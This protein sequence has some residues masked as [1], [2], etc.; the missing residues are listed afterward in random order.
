[1][2]GPGQGPCPSVQSAKREVGWGQ[3]GLGVRGVE[4]TNVRL[5]GPW[6]G[7]GTF[8]PAAEGWSQP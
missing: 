3:T 7:E 2:L 4:S 8:V 6:E 1:M 5:W